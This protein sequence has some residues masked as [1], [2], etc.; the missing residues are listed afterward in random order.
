MDLS[1]YSSQLLPYS[2]NQGF[3]LYGTGNSE[4]F[5]LLPFL[6]DFTL[7]LVTVLYLV[8]FLVDRKKKAFITASIAAVI[9]FVF[10]SDELFYLSNIS[11]YIAVGDYLRDIHGI[12]IFSQ[13]YGSW[14]VS[15]AP[16]DI[17]LSAL[18]LRT[19][20]GIGTLIQKQVRNTSTAHPENPKKRERT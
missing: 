1:Q 14:I 16:F 6:Y 3:I 13:G 8:A 2:D 7:L 11:I 4:L 5:S 15:M 10:H 9:L 17:M 12:N 19:I 18:G 20:W